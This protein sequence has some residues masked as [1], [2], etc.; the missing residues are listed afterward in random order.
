MIDE[1][2]KAA[3]IGGGTMG[4]FNSLVAAVAGY[5]V[6]L[7]D[8]SRES[9]DNAKNRQKEWGAHLVEF[10]G[11]S[12]ELVEKAIAGIK[13]TTDPAEAVQDADLLSESVF[14]KLELKRRTH[15]MF[16]ELCPPK[17]IMT[18]N[19]STLLCSDI[20][21]AVKRGDRFAAMHY[22]QP[23]ILVDLVAGPETDERTM[24]ILKRYVKSCGMI[25]V[26]LKKERGGYL[27]NAM[28]GA[29]LG[30]AMNLVITGQADFREVDRA[31]ML[32]QNAQSGPFASMD[33]VG[34]N[35]IVD[36]SDDNEERGV[37]QESGQPDIRDLF[38]PYVERGELGMKT[39]KGFYSYP[40]P[41]FAQAEFLEGHEE[42]KE[43]TSQIL[44]AVYTTAVTLAHDG[45]AD[46]RDID[47]SWMLTHSPEIGPFGS[48]DEIGL[49]SFIDELEAVYGDDDLAK[50]V[51]AQV[52]DF[53]NPYIEEGHLGVKSGMGFYSYPDPAFKKPGFLL[54]ED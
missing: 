38:R 47:R 13:L 23:G 36:I 25:Y 9:L 42:N 1:I 3:F 34:F 28:Y 17:T 50:L 29:F 33:H 2:K 49:D 44:N 53:I 15:A 19:T 24:D 43:I 54:N 48:I 8:I 40:N 41:E 52:K 26:M 20:A 45:H 27:H 21:S 7:F 11:R 39:G 51:L 10:W 14:E 31:W 37:E 32:N 6:T 35:V 12:P 4:S 18:T 16:D 22:H 46:I 5:E 30:T